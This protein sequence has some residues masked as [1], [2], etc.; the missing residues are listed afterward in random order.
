M[1]LFQRFI[2]HEAG[3]GREDWLVLSAI[4]AALTTFVGLWL[5]S[6]GGVQVI[7]SLRSVISDAVNDIGSDVATEAPPLP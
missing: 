3:T 2:W 5:S 4:A 1:E 6:G 7:D